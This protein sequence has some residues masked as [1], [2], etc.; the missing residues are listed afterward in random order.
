MCHRHLRGL[1]IEFGGCEKLDL[2]DKVVVE[3]RG[4]LSWRGHG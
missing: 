3:A 1:R 2:V 4:N